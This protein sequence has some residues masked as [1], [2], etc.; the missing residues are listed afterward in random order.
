MP[1]PTTPPAIPQPIPNPQQPTPGVAPS[2]VG[3]FAMTGQLAVARVGH[4][5]TKLKNG[6]VLVLGGV[7]SSNAITNVVEIYDGARGLWTV[8][9]ARMIEAR[10]GQAAVLLDDGRVWISGARVGVLVSTEFSIPAVL[11][12]AVRRAQ[13][14]PVTSAVAFRQGARSG[15][16]HWRCR[17][18]R[19][20]SRAR[21]AGDPGCRERPDCAGSE[22]PPSPR[23][24]GRQYRQQGILAVG[25]V[26][27]QG[28]SVATRAVDPESYDLA[29]GQWSPVQ[30]RFLARAAAAVGQLANGDVLVSG[31][32]SAA[33]Y[34]ASADL[35]V[36]TT[37]TF[38]SAGNMSEIRSGH[39]ST[40]LLDGRLLLIG[41]N[42][43]QAVR[44][45]AE[46]YG[47]GFFATLPAR[48]VVAAR[49]LG[50]ADNGRVLIVGG[51]D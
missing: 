2:T 46:V 9:Q 50:D 37:G 18:S 42:N 8:V 14:R 19:P 30:G 6:N 11:P 48:L 39:A 43:G 47:G 32:R 25:G 20:A 27:V 40:L 31:G 29:A 4:T 15:S 35:Y 3:V 33:G 1:A 13:P 45:T 23:R 5:A 38:Q 17:R 22:F 7:D 51:A 16:G 36:A 10:V 21:T 24:A 12:Y 44:D 34:E 28:S 26:T 41:G 49:S